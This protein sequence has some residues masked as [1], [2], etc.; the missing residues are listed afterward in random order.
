VTTRLFVYGTLQPGATHWHLLQP[1]VTGGPRPATLAGTLYDTGHGYPALRPGAGPGVSGWIV[2]LRDPPEPALSAMDEYEGPEYRR[3]LTA[4]PD[5]TPC[6]TYV[7][8]SS[9][10]DLR[11]RT[12]PWPS[13]GSARHS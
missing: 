6:W 10:D 4:L 7:W 13:A 3:V 1:Y 5:N 9:L 11:P 8:V 2:E 12:D